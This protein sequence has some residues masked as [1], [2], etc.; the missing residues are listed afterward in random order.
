MLATTINPM[1][2]LFPWRRRGLY[3]ITPDETDDTRLLE[4]VTAALTAQPAL[5]QYRNKT[6]PPARRWKQALAVAALCR[7]HAVPLIVNDDPELAHA[8]G[9]QGVH[10]GSADAPLTEARALLGTQAIIGISCAADLQRARRAAADGADYV[11]FG[12]FFPTPRK[13]N[14]PRATPELLARAAALGLPRVAIG[15]IG[16]DNAAHLIA[17]GADLIAVIGAV[18]DSDDPRAAATRLQSLYATT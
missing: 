6:L 13:P 4:R 2:S 14:A 10:L 3:L 11:A 16:N 18:F 1:P 8:V 7:S 15:G 9:A 12:A 5:L 17:A